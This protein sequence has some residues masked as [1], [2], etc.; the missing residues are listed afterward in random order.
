VRSARLAVIVMVLYALALLA[1]GAVIFVLAPAEANKATAIAIP[2]FCA[3]I[4]LLTALLTWLGL[5]SPNRAWM[6]KTG[7]H[8]AMLLPF[9]FAALF[10]MP[11]RGR[12][13][14]AER[15]PAVLQEWTAAV[16]SGSVPDTLDAKD[17][18]FREPPS[19]IAEWNAAR[20]RGVAPDD[21]E[22]RRAFMRTRSAP[23]HDITYLLTGLAS[24]IA[25]SLAFGIALVITGLKSRREALAAL[26][27]ALAAHAG[28]G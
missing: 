20:A 25:I 1:A 7:G 18:F 28:R 23:D 6:A 4:M 9:L 17:Q 27:E 8:A 12:M 10:F 21:P 22:A 26:A 16:A 2:G 14:A 5:T 3:G 24:L 11:L 13:A 19:A 15:Y